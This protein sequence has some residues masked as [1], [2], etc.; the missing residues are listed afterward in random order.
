LYQVVAI[1]NNGC[2][3]TAL[4]VVNVHSLSLVPRPNAILVPPQPACA[5]TVP[6]EFELTNSGADSLYLGLPEAATPIQ[7]SSFPLTLV[8]GETRK[9]AVVLAPQALLPSSDTIRITERTCGTS[10][11]IPIAFVPSSVTATATAVTPL[12][13]CDSVLQRNV[14]VTVTNNSTFPLT[15]QSA[16]SSL[17]VGS[18]AQPVTIGAGMA[19]ICS[20]TVTH[21]GSYPAYI[22]TLVLGY[23]QDGCMGVLRASTATTLLAGT[24]SVDSS[25][26]F[27]TIKSGTQSTESIPITIITNGNEPRVTITDVQLTGPFTTT[28]VPGLE[29][30]RSRQRV[31]RIAVDNSKL[32]TNGEATGIL[33]FEI[34]SCASTRKS[35]QLAIEVLPET[36]INDTTVAVPVLRYRGGTLFVGNVLTPLAVYSLRGN[37]VAGGAAVEG[38]LLL[39][40]AKGMYLCVDEAT[41]ALVGKFVVLED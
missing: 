25:V 21:P 12:L 10:T 35:I 27:Q 34:D 3:D 11:A 41:G 30:Q 9:V 28:L 15:V 31:E 8:A 39:E 2:A 19:A 29:L 4:A 20:V 17:F 33:Q 23:K 14:R 38:E 24:I 5:I 6:I 40:L 37:K 18:L 32:P 22:D 16:R 7:S 1:D 36:S 26:R 13:Q